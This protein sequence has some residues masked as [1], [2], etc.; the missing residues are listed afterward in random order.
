M[1]PVGSIL[2]VCWDRKAWWRRRDLLQWMK[3]LKRALLGLTFL[4]FFFSLVLD[5]YQ[6]PFLLIRSDH[7]VGICCDWDWGVTKYGRDRMW[8]SPGWNTKLNIKEKLHILSRCAHYRIIRDQK[9]HAA[10]VHLFDFDASTPNFL[11]HGYALQLPVLP[12]HPDQ[13]SLSL[14]GFFNH[15]MVS[16]KRTH[17]NFSFSF[18]IWEDS[19]WKYDFC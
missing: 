11:S 10:G 17:F 2:P 15:F 16:L 14:Y 5:A 13:A 12:S 9:L 19:K 1:Q 6:S 4:I 3:V 8:N 18:Q 7:F